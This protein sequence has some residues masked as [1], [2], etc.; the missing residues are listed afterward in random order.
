[1]YRVSH[2]S[3]SFTS[4]HLRIIS[5]YLVPGCEKIDAEVNKKINGIYGQLFSIKHTYL[6]DTYC[7]VKTAKHL[8]YYRYLTRSKKRRQVCGQCASFRKCSE[9]LEKDNS[10]LAASKKNKNICT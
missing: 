6:R 2:V 1:M 9:F 10:I 8:H 4:L 5:I 3:I 7:G